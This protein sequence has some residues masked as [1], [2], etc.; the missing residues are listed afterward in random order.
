[1]D[2]NVVDTP[3]ESPEIKE[4]TILESIRDYV[5]IQK[6]LDAFDQELVLHINSSFSTLFQIGV[7]KDK[8]YR[9]EKDSTWSDLFSEY[10]DEL[11]LIKEYVFL[12]VKILFD[13]PTNSSLLESLKSVV[14]ETEY[15]IELQIEGIFKEDSD[16]EK[17]EDYGE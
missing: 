17:D 11:D 10:D 2:D 13:P 12:K 5:G 7:G 1:M 8:P 6:D 9:L 4:E 14:N 15:R 16:E 3:E